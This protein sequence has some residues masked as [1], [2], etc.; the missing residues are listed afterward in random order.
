MYGG[1]YATE[2]VP[3]GWTTVMHCGKY[4]AELKRANRLMPIMNGGEEMPHHLP[5]GCSVPVFSIDALPGAPSEWLREDGCYVCPVEANWG[6]WFSWQRNDPM[7]TAVIASVKGMNPVTGRK[8]EEVCLEQRGK[9]CP[10]HGTKLAS[11]GLCPTCGYILP[12]QN[13]VAAPNV[14]WW[15]GFRQPDGTVRQFFFSEDEARDI[16]S[17]VI[18]KSNVV[19]AFGFAFYKTAV[20]RATPRSVLR[21]ML[22]DY[23]ICGNSPID[24]GACFASPMAVDD[25]YLGDDMESSNYAGVEKEEKTCG[26][27]SG[28]SMYP[29][30]ISSPLP[31]SHPFA[32]S[33]PMPPIVPQSAKRRTSG[34][35]GQ[36]VQPRPRKDV[37]V[38][39]GALISQYLAPDELK[40]SDWVPTCQGLIRLY[41]CFPEQ[42]NAIVNNGGV[43][44]LTGRREGYM[45]GMPVG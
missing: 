32:T 11:T 43:R 36:S 3:K 16:P 25:K 23:P 19:P 29:F 39:A 30:G 18:G 12:P 37:A 44:D 45:K 20:A 22:G 10:L 26:G 28:Q 8:I 42:F 35:G 34:P 41:F 24:V 31:P 13:Y 33:S 1:F 27:I 21:G 17:L 7:N 2:R 4:S 14:L 15:D 6:L 38:G 5:A 9:T 40:L